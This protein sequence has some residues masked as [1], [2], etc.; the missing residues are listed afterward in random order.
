M[1]RV[2]SRS[3]IETVASLVSVC[4]FVTRSKILLI[5]IFDI[6]IDKEGSKQLAS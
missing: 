1:T 2:H 6:D 4:L 3:K 5:L